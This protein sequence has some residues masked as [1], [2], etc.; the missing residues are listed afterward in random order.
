MGEGLKK[1]ISVYHYSYLPLSETFIFRQIQGLTRYFEVSVITSAIENKE[2]FPGIEPLVIPPQNAWTRLMRSERQFF[3]K[4]LRESGLFHVNFGHIAVNMQDHALKAGIPMTA[5]FL[6]VDASACLKAPDYRRKLKAA[7]FAAVFVNSEDMKK[8]LSPFLPTATK[9]HVAYLGI[10]LERF[11]FR[12]RSTVPDDAIFLQVSRL[13]QKKGVDITLKAFSRYLRDYPESRLILA[14]DGPLK[15]DLQRLA[16]SLGI[17]KKVDFLGHI[18]YS[19]YTELL[20]TAH[21]FIH[22][23]ITAANGDMEGLPTAVCE[24]M[25]SGLPVIASRHSGIPEIIDDG[26]DGFLAEEGDIEGVF[27]KLLLLKQVDVEAVSRKARLKIESKF[28]HAKTSAVLARHMSI[29]MSGGI[30]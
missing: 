5:Y 6:G 20:Q 7:K 8:R 30:E 9:C 11:P 25:A 10:P 1:K 23:S 27:N 14:G 26:V 29:I 12:V 2:E 22:P 4:H 28:D 13:D 18:G 3:K 24:A 16:S 19:K 17:E 21:A 15:S